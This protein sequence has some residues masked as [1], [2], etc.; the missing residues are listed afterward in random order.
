MCLG[1]LAYGHATAT[2]IFLGAAGAVTGANDR[3]SFPSHP[4]GA[5][6]R[7]SDPEAGQEHDTADARGPAR[8]DRA[9]LETSP[10]VVLKHR[11]RG[12]V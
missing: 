2:R 5:E 7:R 4:A 1:P 12:F 10:V 11:A 3:E 9:G 6:A 8:A